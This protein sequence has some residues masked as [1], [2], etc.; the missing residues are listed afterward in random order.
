MRNVNACELKHIVLSQIT[1]ND[2]TLLK[3]QSLS[4]K[5]LKLITGYSERNFRT[6]SR[7]RSFFDFGLKKINRNPYFDNL[8][9]ARLRFSLDFQL[10]AVSKGFLSSICPYTGVEIKSNTSLVVNSNLIFFKFFSKKINK[11]FYLIQSQIAKGFLI[12]GVYLPDDKLIVTVWKFSQWSIN[13]EILKDFHEVLIK[14]RYQKYIEKRRRRGIALVIGHQH[15]AHHLWNELT[16]IEKLIDNGLL[17]KIDR[18]YIIN[19]PLGDLKLIFPEINGEKIEYVDPDQVAGRILENN[20]FTIRVGGY[21]IRERLTNRIISVANNALNQS[22]LDLINEVRNKHEILIWISLRAQKRTIINQTSFLIKLIRELSRYDSTIGIVLDGFSIPY[23]LCEQNKTKFINSVNKVYISKELEIADEIIRSI[24][25]EI[26]IYN[27]IGSSIFESILWA[28]AID[29]YFCHH[30]TIQHKVAWFSSKPG[31]IHSNRKVLNK[32]PKQ[33]YQV[34]QDSIKPLYI[35]PDWVKNLDA[36][37]IK[38]IM[39]GRGD[40]QNYMF[41]NEKEIVKQVVSLIRS[42]QN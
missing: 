27:L 39:I 16:G 32:K 5:L 41:K 33:S 11:T 12:G 26:K 9:F 6:N 23:K 19:Q 29:C 34:K 3:E 38:E 40:Y 42:I 18:F 1:K 8:E 7:F 15:F 10:R 21:Y 2:I 22:K 4:V 13:E 37:D 24:P 25:E 14:D 36:S 35:N 31:I 30:G 20:F 17:D 28:N